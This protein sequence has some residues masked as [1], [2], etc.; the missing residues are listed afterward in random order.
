H[1]PRR[2]P[3]DRRDSRRPR[4]RRLPPRLPRDRP[5]PRLPLRAP[6]GAGVN[7]DLA[8]RLALGLGPLL[9]GLVA[10][11]VWLAA[12]GGGRVYVLGRLTWGRCCSAPP[13]PPSSPR[14]CSPP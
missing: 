9:L 7:R 5:R 6:G 10:S 3:P 4:R 13:R 1:H 14:R 12:G 11:L 8:L 2:R